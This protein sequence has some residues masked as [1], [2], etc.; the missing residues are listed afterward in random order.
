[1]DAARDVQIWAGT[2]EREMTGVLGLQND[3]ANSIAEAIDVRLSTEE[4]SE[5]AK[6]PVVDSASYDA[7]LRAMYRIH[8]GSNVV[9]REGIASRKR[10]AR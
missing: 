3:I 4:K 7:Y 5:L 6:Q 10:P 2:F 8:D 9:R 1:M